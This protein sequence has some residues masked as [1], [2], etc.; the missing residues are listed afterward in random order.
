ML[1]RSL[2]KDTILSMQAAKS[3]QKTNGEEG[4]NRY[5]ISQCNSALNVMEVFGLFMLSG[6]Q[7][8]KLSID[9]VPL[10]ETIGDLEN[11]PGVM[12]SLY[13]NKIYRNHLN[14]RHNT[15]TIMLGF[16]DGTKDGGYLMANWGIYKAKQEL[17]K[18]SKQ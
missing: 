8:E 3:I 11:A 15:Q 5:I 4:C 7:A 2:Y 17:T 13:E 9:I 14:R 12:R 18:I 1:F 10:F 6:W 16:S